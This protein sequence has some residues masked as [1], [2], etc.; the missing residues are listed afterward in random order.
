MTTGWQGG[1]E[2]G[3]RLDGPREAAQVTVGRPGFE[4]SSRAWVCRLGQV[5]PSVSRSSNDCENHR[6]TGRAVRSVA[7][8]AGLQQ[9]RPLLPL[10]GWWRGG[11][12]PCTF[13]VHL[14]MLPLPDLPWPP[15][16]S[17]SLRPSPHS[18]AARA[19]PPSPLS[20]PQAISSLLG[21]RSPILLV[22]P[23]RT[24]VPRG[25]G[26]ATR[27]FLRTRS[28]QLLKLAGSPDLA[29]W[30]PKHSPGSRSHSIQHETA[31]NTDS[32][33]SSLGSFCLHVARLL[34]ACWPALGLPVQTSHCHPHCPWWHPSKAPGK[35]GEGAK[36]RYPNVTFWSCWCAGLCSSKLFS[37]QRNSVAS[38]PKESSPFHLCFNKGLLLSVSSAFSL[39]RSAWRAQELFLRNPGPEDFDLYLGSREWHWLNSTAFLHFIWIVSE[40]WVH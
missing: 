7:A 30:P 10:T 37:V 27:T 34:S 32:V 2:R 23:L 28:P 9:T 14:C 4:S 29:S 22:C 12:Q 25:L 21:A 26:D 5:S 38:D 36:V 39:D 1:E 8:H 40:L 16:L 13:L 17:R 19:S 18:G 3:Y 6:N 11:R 15:V 20:L 33:H 35:E 31:G 24:A